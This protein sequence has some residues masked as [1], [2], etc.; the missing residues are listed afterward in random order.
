MGVNPKRRACDEDY[1]TDTLFCW[2]AVE[3]RIVMH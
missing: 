3:K 2:M 1:H